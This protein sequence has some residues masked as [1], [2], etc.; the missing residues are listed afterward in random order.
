MILFRYLLLLSLFCLV[1]RGVTRELPLWLND[2]EI[3]ANNT[4]ALLV[5]TSSTWMNYR[6]QVRIVIADL[7]N[8]LHAWYCNC[9]GEK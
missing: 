5:A 8:D 3:A 2:K 4:W 9:T 6:H 7:A 1:S